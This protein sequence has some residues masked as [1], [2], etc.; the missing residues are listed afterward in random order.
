MNWL[1]FDAELLTNVA[2]RLATLSQFPSFGRT[3]AGTLLNCLEF[4]REL[5]TV[6]VHALI[7]AK[8]SLFRDLPI[9]LRHI[10]AV[11]MS[12]VDNRV[13]IRSF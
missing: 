13:H 3:C 6:Q 11:P 4:A 2:L 5:D 12:V 10:V 8:K 1:Q 7:N 9:I